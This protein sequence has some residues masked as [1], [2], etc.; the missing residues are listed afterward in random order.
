VI[1]AGPVLEFGFWGLLLVFPLL[2]M[3][4]LLLVV[5]VF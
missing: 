3:L 1:W 5:D 4:L 2:L